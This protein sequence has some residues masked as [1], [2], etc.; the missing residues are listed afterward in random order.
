MTEKQKVNLPLKQ[1][2]FEP[3]SREEFRQNT[4][5]RV[6]LISKEFTDG[7]NF[8][9]DFPKS[10][11]F[12]GGSHFKETSEYYIKARL[13]AERVVSELHYSVLTGGGPGIMEAANRGAFES[14]GESIGLTIELPNHQVQ[15]AFLTKNLDFYYF[16]S[17]KVC[18]SFSAEAY[19]FFP[20]GYGTLDEFF[21]I[22]TLIQ[23][24]KLEKIPIILV[25]SDFWKPLDEL[26]KKDLFERGTIDEDDLALYIMTDNEDQI[27]EIIRNAPVH[28][29][30][31]FTHKDL[32][33]SGI[34]IENKN[35]I[36]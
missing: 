2:P 15:N 14:G 21:E 1:L 12:F 10:V 4:K 31:K 3:N 32:H 35:N 25:G 26:I 7:F 24:G 16:F 22:I 29:G 13:L 18:L 20:G 11:T 23:T 30:I 19:V 33:S 6:G 8:L 5:E 28:Q 27:I 36:L 9:Q 34:E 17:R